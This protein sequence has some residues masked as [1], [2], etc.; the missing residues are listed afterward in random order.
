MPQSLNLSV[1]GLYTSLNDYNGL[2]PGALDAADN[3]E[4]RYKNVLEPRRG[5]ESLEDSAMALVHLV[6]LTNFYVL[7]EDAIV[8]LTSEGDLVYYDGSNPWPAIPGDVV[9]NLMA[10]DAVNGKCRFIHAGQ[11]LYLTAQDGVRSLASG[12]DSQMLRAG[13]PKGLN[14]EAETNGDAD[15]FFSNN[16][17]LATTGNLTNA[18]AVISG[19]TDTTGIATDQYV[20][21]TDIDATL[22]VQDLTYTSL[23]F[24]VLG[25]S[26]TI[27]Y[28]GGASLVVSVIADAISVQLNTGVS[29]AA[30]VKTAVDALPA[31]AALVS[32][33]VTGTGSNIQIAAVATPLAGGLDNTIPIGTKVFSITESAP[34]IIETGNT[35]AGNTTVSNLVSITGIVAG[36]LVTGVG[37]PDNTRVVSSTGAGPYDIVLTLAAYQT[38]TAVSLT[39]SSALIVT[40]DQN[41]AATKAGGPISFYSG[42]QVGYRMVFGRVET[43]INDGTLTRLGSASSIAI[44]TNTSPY[45]TNVTVTG[46]IPKNSSE[47]ITFVQL[48]RSPQTDSISI[49]PLDQYNLVYER[50]LVAGDFTARVITVTDEVPDSLVGIPLYSGSDQEGILQSNDPPPMCW[51]MCKFRDFTLFG[52]ITRPT[53]L[54]VTIVSVGS[55][56]GIQLNDTITISGSFLSVPFTETYTAKSAENA[57]SREF[58]FF[59]SGTPSQNIA[60]T[61]NSLIR[62]INYDNALPVHAILLSSSTDLPGQILFEADNPSYD[63]FTVDASAHE[64]AYDPELD[65]VVSEINVLNNGI[66]V[67]K[68]GE[69]EAVPLT[70]LLFAGDSSSN[71]LR[72]IALRDYVIVLKTDGIYKVQG[73]SPSALVIN[74]FD[75]T[76]KIIGADT[77]VSLN[78][79]V[80]MLSNQGVVSISDGGVDA[81]SV[82]IDDQLNR[83]IGSYLDNLTNTSFAVGYESDRKYI[84]CVPDSTNEF[85][86]IEYNFNYVTHAWTTWTRNFFTGFIHSA[87][88]KLYVSRADPTDQGISRERKQANYKDYVDESIANSIVSID[89]TVV[90]LSDID[91]VE[92]GDVLFQDETHFSP[93]VSVDLGSSEITIQSAL[94]FVAGD[95]EILKAYECSVTWKQVFGDNPAFTRQFSEGIALF[96]NTRFN[97]AEMSFV[98][99]FSQAIDSVTL[100]GTGNSLWGLFPWGNAPWGGTVLPSKIRFLVPQ[101]KQLGSYIIPTLSIKQGYSDFR[102]EGLAMMYFNISGEV[103]K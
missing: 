77:A 7:G 24:G 54:K 94:S 61:A 31:A 64:S 35:T 30:Q 59:T 101:S 93:I 4:S 8:A 39:F 70:N 9:T 58:K 21:G 40:M 60:D 38:A 69:F 6:R 99:D 89:E 17:V 66:G 96:K 43:D 103:G 102:F 5:F 14:L 33:A 73:L 57:A 88:D 19:L 26:I 71:L 41:A 27:R 52:N 56:N 63:T 85:A 84:L 48:Y 95:C 68:P 3:V 45:S 83:L 76:T 75:L 18:S 11:N 34:I 86:E 29:T 67:S 80:W 42:S 81:K 53:T 46:T 62:V 49:T 78:S 87:Q 92:E 25:N 22:V 79:G 82:P 12:A 44:C 55:P 65:S 97:T 20:T 91:N 74:P 100:S 32:V 90:V 36:V 28:T 2:P 51:D 16:V 50:E 37:I 98:T 10:P 1:S 15:G 13:V 47:E 72:M 23:L